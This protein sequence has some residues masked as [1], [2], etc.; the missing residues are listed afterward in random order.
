MQYHKSIWTKEQVDLDCKYREGI[1]SALNLDRAKFN[2]G[3]WSW[4]CSTVPT[5]MR[6]KSVLRM[7]SKSATPVDNIKRERA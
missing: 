1:V 5:Y 2:E 6:E 3:D 7:Q 4:F